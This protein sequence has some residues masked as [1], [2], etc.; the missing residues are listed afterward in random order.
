MNKYCKFCRK[1]T[2]VEEINLFFTFH[3]DSG[4]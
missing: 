1:H 3:C 4:T 2:V